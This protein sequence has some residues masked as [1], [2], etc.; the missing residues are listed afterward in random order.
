[1]ASVEVSALVFDLF[2]KT[3][4]RVV[5]FTG[6]EFGRDLVAYVFALVGRL[7]VW[8]LC[9]G[10]YSRPCTEHNSKGGR[11]NG[12]SS[13]RAEAAGR[14]VGYFVGF[15]LGTVLT[16]EALNAFTLPGKILGFANLTRSTS[17]FD[18]GTSRASQGVPSRS[19]ELAV[20]FVV[21]ARRAVRSGIAV[22]ACGIAVKGVRSGGAINALAFSRSTRWGD[23]TG[24][25]PGANREVVC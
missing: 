16:V 18:G 20:S 12:G 3:F 15:G 17:C 21:R 22:G 11:L 10:T 4:R 19:A 2:L 5:N 14:I 25:A 7:S 24:R 23:L 1:M 13:A 8:A 9:A 6:I